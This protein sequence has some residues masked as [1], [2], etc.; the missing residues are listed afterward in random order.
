VLK[1][2]PREDNEFDPRP[3]D[4]DNGNGQAARVIE[5]LRR[6]GSVEEII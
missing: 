2:D 4:R 3:Y 1:L 6:T 5:N